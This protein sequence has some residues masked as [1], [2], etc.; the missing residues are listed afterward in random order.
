M[1]KLTKKTEYALIAIKHFQGVDLDDIS[2]ARTISKIYSIPFP[3]LSKVL[4]SMARKK[5]I[6]PVQG[7]KG[8]YRLIIN[9]KETN[10]FSFL[11][12]MEGPFGFANCLVPSGCANAENCVIQSPIQKINTQLQLFFENLT[13]SDIIE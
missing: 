6:E 11:E 1:L 8:G 3:I 10:L 7:A 5:L 12:I 4:Q 2:T 13:I 9:P